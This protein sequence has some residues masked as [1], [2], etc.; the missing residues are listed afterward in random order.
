MKIVNAHL[1]HSI[2]EQGLVKEP[3]SFGYII[4]AAE[5]ELPGLFTSNSANKKA[6]LAK[7]K[8]LSSALSASSDY[9]N[10][11]D[12]FDAF[13]IPPGTKEGKRLIEEKNYDVH[14]ATFDIVVL[15]ECTSVKNALIVRELQEL[16]DILNLIDLSASYTDVMTYQNVARIDEVSK[17]SNG[18][19]LFNFFFSEDEQT[20]LDV[21]NYTAGW[22]T[23]KANLTNSTPMQ[24]VAAGATYSLVNH[25]RW[26]KLIDVLPSLIFKP[27]MNS[28]VLKNFTENNI[29][30]MPIL[31]KL[32]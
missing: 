28:F 18:I 13:I 6:L 24:A 23:E 16:E 27:S 1:A 14:I 29:V 10:R 9:V 5:V 8:T 7:V 21:W 32:A 22:W 15:I 25:C 17:D 12:V 20:L 2:E 31:Y 30:A 19:F 26:D 3:N 11:A 4:I